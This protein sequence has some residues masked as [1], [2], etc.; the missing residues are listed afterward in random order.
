MS[1]PDA[2]A[3]WALGADAAVEAGVREENSRLAASLASYVWML[4]PTAILIVRA[5]PPR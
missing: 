1:M 4:S 3:F 2:T 5:L